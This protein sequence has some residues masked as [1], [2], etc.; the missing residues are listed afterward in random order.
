MI[1]RRESLDGI[2]ARLEELYDAGQAEKVEKE[3][4]RARRDHPGDLTLLE[5]EATLAGDDG[6]YAEALAFLDEVLAIQPDRPFAR[7]E[8]VTVLMDLGR[9]A[10]ALSSLEEIGPDN[11][12]D[13][14]Y[15][16]DR[17]LCL[18][19]LTRT[20]EAD[21]EFREAERLAPE[22]LTRPARLSLEEFEEVARRAID[23]IPE[24]LR[25]YLDNV[26]VEVM[27]YPSSPPLDPGLDPNLLGLYVGVA[28]TDRTQECRD[29][30]DRIFIFKRNL[31]IE[32]PARA[33]LRE[34]IRKTVIHE[35]AHHFGLGEED[36]G[37]YA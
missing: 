15:H 4:R 21:R 3:L 6:R 10:E 11:A 14:A 17:A 35:I 37:D 31:E 16:F 27:D 9:F 12:G 5:W 34:E 13:S 26:I 24:A 8:K 30:L 22:E 18:D 36:M 32:F 19:R 25:K 7:R 20:E 29:N 23:E 28:R 1:V 33:R 2:L